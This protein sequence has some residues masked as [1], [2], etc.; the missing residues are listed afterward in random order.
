MEEK[1]FNLNEIELSEEIFYYGN[2][3]TQFVTINIE[4]GQTYERHTKAMQAENKGV[5]LLII[6]YYYNKKNK[7]EDIKEHCTY[8]PD[9]KIRKN[10]ETGNWDFYR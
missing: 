6:S 3:K 1:R 9:L 10:K 5:V 7:I 4:K 2:E 8:L